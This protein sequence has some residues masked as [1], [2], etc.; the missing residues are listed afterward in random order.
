[1]TLQIKDAQLRDDESGDT[2]LIGF[3]VLAA[4]L[5]PLVERG[6]V[7][8]VDGDWDGTMRADARM[9]FADLTEAFTKTQTEPCTWDQL[10]ALLR[11]VAQLYDLE[12]DGRALP[13]GVSDPAISI[14][15]YDSTAWEITGD[16]P[17][18]DRA[19]AAFRDTTFIETPDQLRD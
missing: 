3:D 9:N 1:M 4:A 18:L 5:A 6:P 17:F 15:R 19:A 14:V 11:P 2:V 12:I 7:W 13:Q 10:V 16:R 8:S